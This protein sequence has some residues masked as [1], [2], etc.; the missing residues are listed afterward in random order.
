MNKPDRNGIVLACILVLAV[1]GVIFIYPYSIGSELRPWRLGLDL[2]G[3]S[4]LQYEIDMARIAEQDRNS[5]AE[6]LKDVIERR[7]NLFGVSEPQIYISKSEGRYR[8]VAEL[9]GIRDVNEA[10]KE[11]G[12]TPLLDFREVEVKETASTSSL[13]A[14]DLRFTPTA[15]TGRFVTGA[16]LAFNPTTGFP[17][18]TLQFNKDGE[19][20]FEALTE[21]NIGK[22][23]AIFLD[24]EPISM[25]I[26]QT[27]IP[28][29]KAQISGKFTIEEARTLVERL[30][31]GA[32]PAPITLISQQT[33]GATLGLSS[34]RNIITAGVIGTLIVALF[35]IG[36]YRLLGFFAAIALFI[37]IIFTLFIFKAIPITMTLSGIA[38]FILSI[39]MA[40]D[41]NI[42]IFE[43]VKEEL[44][45]GMS[46]V[47]ALKEGFS[48]AWPSIRDSNISTMITAFILYSFTSSFVK[49]FALTLFIGVLV[50]MFSAIT[51]TRT[52]LNVFIK[53]KQ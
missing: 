1:G 26:V 5:V 37:Y 36:Y 52:L 33:I 49:G 50:S 16:Q 29:G 28:G 18:V 44:K 34:L 24:N 11:I 32:L 53:E 12:A 42:L 45:R 20:I 17:E 7:V 40:V 2:V 10:I 35:M 31:A 23:L 8:L 19:K 39:G 9:A 46:R 43:R 41:A 22:P 25:P 21:K 51:I 47:N 38:G 6:G 4:Y 48:R 13:S 27:K 15:L 30:N 3:G 14:D